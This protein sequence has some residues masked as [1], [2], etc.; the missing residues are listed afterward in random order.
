MEG[1]CIVDEFPLTVVSIDSQV[2]KYRLS[3]ALYQF[4][5]IVLH[6]LAVALNLL[7]PYIRNDLVPSKIRHNCVDRTVHPD[8][9]QSANGNHSSIAM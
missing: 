9:L 5:Q 8:S 6:V 4:D 3:I 1:R 2:L 7:M